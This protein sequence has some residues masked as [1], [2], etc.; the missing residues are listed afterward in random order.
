MENI[1]MHFPAMIQI[2][3]GVFPVFMGSCKRRKR[4]ERSKR[5]KKRSGYADKAGH[6]TIRTIFSC[7]LPGGSIP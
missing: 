4:Y 1:Y 3:D 7:Y 2:I 5:D 6:T